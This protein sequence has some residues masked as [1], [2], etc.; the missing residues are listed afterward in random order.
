MT[1]KEIAQN[2][3]LLAVDMAS[4][5]FNMEKIDDDN[6]KK[7]AKEM[8]MAAIIANEWSDEINKEIDDDDSDSE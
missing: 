8:R 2:L 3:Y 7:H 6:M 1:K 4:L 5:A